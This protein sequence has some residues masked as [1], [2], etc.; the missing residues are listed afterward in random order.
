[1]L[2]IPAWRVF[3]TDT[4]LPLLADATPILLAIVGVV[5]SYIQPKKESHRATTVV[6]IFAGIVGT[7]VLS[8]NRINSEHSHKKEIGELNAKLDEVGRQNTKLANFLLDARNTGKITEVE[9]R[10]GVEIV[11][12]N[13]YILSHNPIDPEI[14]AGNKTPPQDWMNRRLQEMRESWT[15]AEDHPAKQQPAPTQRSYVLFDG[16]PR[17][18]GST[19]KSEG[20]AFQAGDPFGFNVYYRAIGPNMIKIF[21]IGQAVFLEPDSALETQKSMLSKYTALIAKEQKGTPVDF[22]TATPGDSRVFSALLLTDPPQKPLVTQEVLENL[23]NGTE[24]AFVISE[25]LY[26]DSVS[27]HHARLCYWLQPPAIPPGVWH[28]CAVFT[29]SD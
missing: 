25:V 18:T 3:G 6:L 23:R 27:K 10:K 7:L 1:V 4:S 29:K 13:E 9:R 8:A 14:L 11:L 19:S 5:M 24:I 17:F 26:E 20:G 12:R 2:A 15:V 16:A 22:A 21:G 28:S